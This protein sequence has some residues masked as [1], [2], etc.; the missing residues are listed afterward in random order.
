MRGLGVA[1]SVAD[2]ETV[3]DVVA[4]GV[5]L[6]VDVHAHHVDDAFDRLAAESLGFIEIVLLD[7][8]LERAAAAYD[9]LDAGQLSRQVVFGS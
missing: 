8:R 9:L 2:V 6:D 4:S 5:Y 7:Q 1:V 3:G